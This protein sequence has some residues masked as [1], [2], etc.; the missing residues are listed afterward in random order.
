L[1]AGAW[2]LSS[3]V[4]E[5]E[6]GT[7]VDLDVPWEEAVAPPGMVAAPIAPKTPT[8]AMPL[9]AIQKVSRRS[10]RRRL[11]RVF[12][13]S[14]GRCHVCMAPGCRPPLD[15]LCEAAQKSL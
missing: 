6:L 12:A 5:L 11:S 8:P 7:V 15:R 2:T 10:P 13:S 14:L 9:A 1:L 3:L 4:L